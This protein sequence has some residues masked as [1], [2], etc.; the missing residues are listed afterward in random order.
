MA[1]RDALERAQPVILEPLVRLDI[2]APEAGLGDVTADLSGRRA[3]I[4]G[5]TSL[6][7][8]AS[9][10]EAQAPLSE[11]AEYAGRLRSLTAGQGSFVTELAHYD[12]LPA[13]LQQTVLRARKKPRDTP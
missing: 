13:H 9:Q 8:G 10:I 6:S 7:S 1:V 12:V 4:L 11:L 2:T 3:R 5:V